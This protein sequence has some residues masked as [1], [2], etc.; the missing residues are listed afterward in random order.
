MRQKMQSL[1]VRLSVNQ[2]QDVRRLSDQANV[3]A[4]QWMRDA[5]RDRIMRES[6]PGSGSAQ[7]VEKPA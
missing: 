1:Q 7:P 6:A 3:S 4:S 5:V 2:I